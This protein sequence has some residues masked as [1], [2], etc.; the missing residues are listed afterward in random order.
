MLAL[1]K[2][3]AANSPLMMK[4]GARMKAWEAI[5]FILP[6]SGPNVKRKFS[7]PSEQAFR[8][9]HLEDRLSDIRRLADRLSEEKRYILSVLLVI[10]MDRSC[11]RGR[12][13]KPKLSVS[14]KGVCSTP[15]AVGAWCWR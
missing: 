3:V 10:H 1:V 6:P 2:E 7:N 5:A 15:S 12:I 14:D 8:I 11:Y 9:S 13:V 4:V